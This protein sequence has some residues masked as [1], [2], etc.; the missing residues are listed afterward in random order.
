M[1]IKKERKKERKKKKEKKKRKEKGKEKRDKKKGYH[2]NSL[3]F[4]S[5]KNISPICYC[6]K[7][8]FF[9]CYQIIKL[10]NF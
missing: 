10:Y 6:I 1:N 7:T 3:F 5:R 9:S 4:S 8:M 2:C